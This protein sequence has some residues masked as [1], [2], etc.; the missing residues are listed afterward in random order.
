LVFDFLSP[1]QATLQWQDRTVIV[2]L[3]KDAQKYIFSLLMQE[4]NMVQKRLIIDVVFRVNK[5]CGMWYLS[6]KRKHIGKDMLSVGVK[7]PRF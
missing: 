5:L 4:K 1:V 3:Q 6:K 7:M 2:A